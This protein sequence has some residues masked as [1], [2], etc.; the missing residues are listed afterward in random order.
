MA[1]FGGSKSDHPMADIKAAKQLIAE[2]PSGDPVKT[3]GE[4]TYWLDSVAQ[5][6]EFKVEHRYALIDLLDQAAKN[7]QRKLSQEYLA[8]EG[9]QKFSEHR[10]WKTIFDFW[11][12]LGDAYAQCLAQI[13]AGANAG[14]LRNNL[15]PV[16][17]R[18]LRTLTLQIKWTLLRYSP[19]EQRIWKE[20]GRAYQFAEERGINDVVIDIYPGAHGQ[21]SVD[22]EF[23]KALIL[24]VS[25]TDGLS[26]LEQEIAERLVANFGAQFILRPES[27]A[28]CNYFFDLDAGHPAAR[29]LKGAPKIATTRFFGAGEALAAIQRLAQDTRQKDAVPANVHLG[30]TYDIDLVLSVIEHLALY[31]AD[32]VPARSSQ[33]RAVTTQLAVRRGFQ[34]TTNLLSSSAA[35]NTGHG[36]ITEKWVVENASDGGYGAVIPPNKESDSLHIGG[37]ICMRTETAKF[38]GVGIVRRI[39]RDQYQQYHVGIQALSRAAIPVQVLAAGAREGNR[40]VLLSSS[41]DA[42][43]EV[44]V[45]LSVGSYAQNRSYEM[46]VNNKSYLLTPAKLIEGGDDFDW[47]RYKLMQREK[48]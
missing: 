40:A 48:A 28:G 44:E 45:L 20:I 34:A 42:N 30:G 41:P 18:V 35:N 23:L 26:M 27:T 32:E 15:A 8:L 3:I 11:K 36:G 1:L 29:V 10:L 13:E 47:A 38:W 2:L 7:P 6:E 21:S 16:I 31:W 33:R 5:A 22:K 43:G 24:S 9:Q 46:Q 19:I 4:I 12:H 37:L 14:T 25:S 17:A 39:A